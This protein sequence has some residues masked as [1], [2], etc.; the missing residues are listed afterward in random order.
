MAGVYRVISVMVCALLW[1]A[2]FSFGQA[3]DSLKRAELSSKLEEYVASIE[4][5]PIALQNAEVEYIIDACTTPEAK[6]FTASKLFEMYSDP[7][8]MGLEAVAV[9]IYDKY[10]KTGAVAFGDSS[11]KF[12]TEMFVSMNRKTL[13]G[14]A[15]PEKSLLA[16]D[17]AEVTFPLRGRTNLLFF[18]S[19]DCSKCKME[20]VRIKSLLESGRYPIDFVAIYLK[21]DMEAWKQF[22]EERLDISSPALQVHHLWDP[23]GESDIA[24]D[25]GLIK[26]PRIFL[27]DKDGIIIGRNLEAE[28]LKELLE[29]VFYPEE[30]K[31]KA[32][33]E[34]VRQLLYELSSDRTEDGVA[35]ARHLIDD[36]VRTRPE[37]WT[38]AEDSLEVLGLADLLSELYS[39]AEVG[40]K[41]PSVK[42]YAEVSGHMR[43]IR[44]SSLKGN[45]TLLLFH[46]E[47]CPVC[48]GQI[49]KAVELL[50]KNPD[51]RLVS[52]SVDE[53][54]S[55]LKEKDYSKLMDSFDLASL[56]HLILLSSKGIVVRKYFFL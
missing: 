47:G 25:Y 23:S 31:D 1:G 17:G 45:E 33:K 12:L 39:R 20:S 44:L 43:K 24:S 10:Y 56:P 48:A 51:L 16:P 37:L 5:E 29:S 7:K 36:Y 46:T 22:R 13:L 15:A 26:T 19:T 21:D 11:E 30:A 42:V 49:E 27:T 41:V 3:L 32:Y 9:H 50:R 54:E 8:I 55:R 38:S 28:S 52:I 14:A 34:T 18:Y 4:R 53:N 35:A 6:S 40:T 2:Q